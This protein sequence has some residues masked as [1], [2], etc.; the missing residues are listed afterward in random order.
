MIYILGIIVFGILAAV[1]LNSWRRGVI[2]LFVWLLLEDIVRRLVPGQPSQMLLIKDAV[3]FLVYLSFLRFFILKKQKIWKPPFMVALFLFAAVCVINVFNLNSP[4]LLFGLVGLRSYLWYLPLMFLGY[5]MFNDKESLLKF[6]QNLVY[7]SIPLCLFAI[8]QYFFYNTGWALVRSFSDATQ[9]HSFGLSIGYFKAGSIPLLSSVFGVSHRYGRFAMLLFFLGLG[10]LATEYPA[11]L[12]IKKNKKL[13]LVSVF[14][15]FLGIILSGVRA[16][17]VLAVIGGILFFLLAKHNQAWHLWRNS[18][19]WIF[20]LM[21][22][23]LLSLPVAFLFG[24]SAFFQILSFSAA[25]HERIPSAVVAFYS[26]LANAKFFGMGTGTLSQGVTSIPGGAEW[27]IKNRIL[28]TQGFRFE[29]GFG[30]TIFELGIFGTIIFYIFWLCLFYQ[31]IK[32]IKI[33]QNNNLR[34]LGLGIIIFSF[35]MLFWFTFV[36]QQVLG[37]ATTLVILWFFLG[38]FFGLR[39]I[40]REY[41]D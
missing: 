39:K 9:A 10:L 12:L 26:A 16:A 14:S 23:I 31:G 21:A 36:H 6:S 3:V 37:D 29:T 8:F 13:L 35:L 33:L 19:V 17:F 2:L 32:E 25:F 11:D 5:Y 41:T 20:P 28:I 27:N 4:G 18:R 7:I 34:N 38:V 30:R 22:I 1:I 15:S 24:N 40:N